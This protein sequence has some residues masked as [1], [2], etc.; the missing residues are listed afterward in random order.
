MT[1]QLFPQSSLSR[2]ANLEERIQGTPASRVAA[3]FFATSALFPILDAIRVIAIEGWINYLAEFAHYIL[4]GAAFAQAL[5]LGTIKTDNWATR[6]FGNLL[7]LLLYAAIDVSIEGLEFFS[8]PYHWLFGIFSLAMAI[9][10]ALQ[11]LV[12]K[13]TVGRAVATLL[14]NITKVSL[15][16]AMYFISELNLEV[17]ARLTLAGWQEYM[18]NGGHQ[19]LFYGALFLGLLLGLAEAQRNTYARVLQFI[20]RQLKKYSEWS[21]SADLVAE[22]IDNPTTL[23]LQRVK[24][25]ILFM[26]VRGFTAWTEKTDPQYAV[27]MLNRYYTVAET[28]IERHHGHKPNFTADEVMTRFPTAQA[29]LDTALDL[30]QELNLL[31]AKSNLAVGIGLH[32]G[33]II[34]GLMGSNTTRKYDIIGDAV[35]TA[36]RLES[37]AGRGEIVVSEITCRALER[38]ISA[39]ETRTLQVKGKS[40]SLQVFAIKTQ[41]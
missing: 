34:E 15:F 17:S 23:H 35:N 9:F 7:G 5:F 14:L 33:E 39:A 29:A 40:E 37:A 24:K 21:L 25:T 22:A 31:L 36:K 32:T 27:N 19:F 16:P 3:E 6:F 20:A 4:F 18:Q 26:D 2:T 1:A 38:P 30:Q 11:W 8:Q 41:Q 13:N 10:S 28:V 12:R